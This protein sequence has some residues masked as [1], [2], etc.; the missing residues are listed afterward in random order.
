MKTLIW[1]ILTALIWG[2]VPII[3]K[4]GLMKAPAMVGLFYRSLGVMIGITVLLMMQSQEIRA[5]F[6]NFDGRMIYLILGGFLASF[7]GQIFFYHALKSGDASR[8]VPVSGSYPLI[9]FL[10]G[11]LILGEKFTLAK[12]GGVALVVVGVF[13]LT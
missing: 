10:L 6:R 13:L 4:I 5:S 3:E 2:G 11:V 7:L 9:T 12:A 8:V 1:A